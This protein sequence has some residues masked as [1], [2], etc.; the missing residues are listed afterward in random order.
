MHWN[1][2]A[3][4]MYRRTGWVLALIL[5]ALVSAALHSYVKAN[6]AFVE[7]EVDRI[8]NI[9]LGEPAPDF[10]LHDID[11]KRVS[12]SDLRE[13]RTV[14]LVFW[15]TWCPSCDEV[16]MQLQ[17]LSAGVRHREVEFLAVNVGEGP[18][19]V[20]EYLEGLSRKL[21]RRFEEDV[22]WDDYTL[23]A[24]MDPRGEIRERYGLPGIPVLV[25]AGT[26]GRIV[27]IES[28]YPLSGRRA[29]LARSDWFQRVFEK[30]SSVSE[31]T[32]P[33]A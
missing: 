14:V 3:Q 26:D 9:A 1:R 2:S 31:P 8:G 5:F 32:V 4:P 27:H 11:G 12:I 30:L 17:Q 33:C 18:E 15:T 19:V 24:L 10:S 23:G 13:Q 6:F 25:I 28:G 16:L 22:P 21:K 20:R 29:W 7:G